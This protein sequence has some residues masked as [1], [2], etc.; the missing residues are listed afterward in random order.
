MKRMKNLRQ[1]ARRAAS[2]NKSAAGAYEKSAQTERMCVFCRR[3]LPKVELIRFVD[4]DGIVVR[5]E[6]GTYR[7]RGAY[8]C[9]EPVC[10]QKAQQDRKGLLKKALRIG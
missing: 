8:C 7:G 6:Q 3:R 5:D 10:M 2:L 4:Q 9:K 1:K